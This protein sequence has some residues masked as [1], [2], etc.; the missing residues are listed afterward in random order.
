[1]MPQMIAMLMFLPVLHHCKQL[2]DTAFD[3]QIQRTSL[4]E[5]INEFMAA[6]SSAPAF[7]NNTAPSQP[8]PALVQVTLPK[9]QGL[10]Y[11]II[12]ADDIRKVVNTSEEWFI[13]PAGYVFTI[14]RNRNDK[15]KYIYLH[16][17]I[18]GGTAKHINGDRLDNKK[19]N[20]M[21]TRQDNTEEP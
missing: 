4:H 1:M 21:L 10:V 13:N 5:S 15:L 2:V 20:L 3:M 7:E 18:A 11:A 9:N 12:D 16:K 6:T 14:K 17:L 8:R 19:S